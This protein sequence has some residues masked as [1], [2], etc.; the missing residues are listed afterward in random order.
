MPSA[1]QEM[2]RCGLVLLLLATPVHAAGITSFEPDT[3][4]R[5]PPRDREPMVETPI[6]Y[7]T[8]LSIS[9]EHRE[10]WNGFGHGING[11]SG[12]GLSATWPWRSRLQGWSDWSYAARRVSEE[13][14]FSWWNG[15]ENVRSVQRVEA[16]TD[17]FT[18]RSGVE[19]RFGERRRP[20]CTA[21]AGLGLGVSFDDGDPG[22]LTE[23]L[24]RVTCFTYP[25]NRTRLGL[26]LSGG[27]VWLGG[28]AQPLYGT[29]SQRNRMFTYFE[30][31]LRVESRLRFPVANAD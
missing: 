21:G 19:Y 15:F 12:I 31:S 25:S 13:Y 22:A 20:W 28:F 27:P 29:A 11:F 5:V 3:T 1:L 9:S 6:W 24:A 14:E 16:T 26:M 7:G 18:G 10:A 8:S 17:V 2:F 30:L 23:I 4:Q